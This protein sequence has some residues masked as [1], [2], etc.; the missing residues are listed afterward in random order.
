[1]PAGAGL[2]GSVGLGHAEGV[3]QGR[4]AGL[5]IELG[6]LS[7]VGLLAKVVEAEK[8]GAALHLGLHHRGRADLWRQNKGP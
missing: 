7:Q 4:Y 3:A 1:M 6:G 5:Q 2:L 8:R